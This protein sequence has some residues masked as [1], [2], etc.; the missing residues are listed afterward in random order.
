M[1]TGVPAKLGFRSQTN[2]ESDAMILTVD[3]KSE[4]SIQR[5]E[6]GHQKV[7]RKHSEII[8]GNKNSEDENNDSKEKFKDVFVKRIL[9]EEFVYMPDIPEPVET[10]TKLKETLIV[11]PPPAL[12]STTSVNTE[13][14]LEIETV[15]SIVEVEEVPGP[16]TKIVHQP[17]NIIESEASLNT[18]PKTSDEEIKV[19]KV[20]E[21]EIIAT[22]IPLEKFL[23]SEI[24]I[25]EKSKLVVEKLP[26]AMSEPE[27]EEVVKY[28]V[29]VEE[30][31]IPDAMIEQQQNTLIA[32]IAPLPSPPK[33][34]DE[35]IKTV[36]EF[37][38]TSISIPDEKFTESEI[39][40][41]E[42]S[43]LVIEKLPDSMV[44]PDK[45]EVVKVEVGVE[46]TVSLDK[47]IKQQPNTLM[48]PATSL[49]SLLTYNG[50]DNITTIEEATISSISIPDENFPESEI[51]IIEQSKLIVEKLPKAVSG[52]E[53][54]VVKVEVGVEK[55]GIPDA[56]IEQQQ[57]TLMA[58][59]APMTSLPK[60]N[61]DEDI[62]T[63]EE[64]R[65][66]SIS[67]PDEHFVEA[68]IVIVEQSKL[69]IEKLPKAMS[70]PSNEEVV[71][72]EV[73]F[74]EAVI[75]DTMIEQQQNTMIAPAA[76]MTYLP[77]HYGD[78][79]IKTVEEAKVSTISITGEN[80]PES[81]IVIIEQSKLVVGKLSKAMG[82]PKNEVV[83]VEVGV[84]V[85]QRSDTRIKQESNTL[86]VP[87]ASQPSLS[88]PTD[89]DIATVKE[90]K[91]TFVSGPDEISPESEIV[92]V[93]QS[94]LVVEK[95]PKGMCKSANEEVVKLEVGIEEAVNPDMIQQQPNTLMA[96]AALLPSLPKHNGNEDIMT[97]EEDKVSF[98]SI[99]E[100][101]FPDSEIVIVEQSKVVVEKLH[102]AISEPA[103][104]VV[105][106]VK[107]GVEEAARPDNLVK[108]QPNTLIAFTAPLSSTEP[109][110]EDEDSPEFE[111]VVV[112]QSALV[113]EK[114]EKDPSEPAD[115]KVV[116]VKEALSLSTINQH[117]M[118]TK[119]NST[120]LHLPT[121]SKELGA[122]EIERSMSIAD[123]NNQCSSQTHSTELPKCL[124]GKYVCQP[125]G[126]FIELFIAVIYK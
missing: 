87:A 63:A 92:I 125:G 9:V 64:A 20:G 48:V 22:P 25:I 19:G 7:K 85:A 31:V 106:K 55:A 61:G 8:C 114:V 34:T 121:N 41:I 5:S 24:V 43:K 89:Q 51:V 14:Y 50:D 73:G 45:E 83:K 37:D 23:Q 4:T 30:A 84:E 102:G 93:E 58:P 29:G 71:K 33:S 65:V 105:V 70:E 103:N 77:K 112:E 116:D 122:F 96:P 2:H 38:V 109:A 117:E 60:Y 56:M 16:D 81:E 69:V 72:V 49:P 78:E 1:A 32:P 80:F 113:L 13:E 52:P 75:P 68:E 97:V 120:P 12:T 123:I 110:D 28:E 98:F 108:Q 74:G 3:R 47:K 67:I 86:I 26:K 15:E 11:P 36:E 53:N 42:Q 118:K 62:M 124:N 119:P 10:V 126:N 46:E 91:V 104:E 59:V 115:K 40:I 35:D 54:E 88:K 18:P 90:A 44:E 79:D 101:I 27:N 111:V 94:K 107:V 21:A 57:N 39:V 99:S 17:K 76:P 95:L 82:D 66:S 100:E 6:N